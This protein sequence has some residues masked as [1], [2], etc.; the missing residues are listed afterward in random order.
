MPANRGSRS[1]SPNPGTG[2][3]KSRGAKSNKSH[4]SRHSQRGKSTGRYSKLRDNDENEI[5]M[6]DLNNMNLA[7]AEAFKDIGKGGELRPHEIYENT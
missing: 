1:I 5:E 4:K 2:S 3:K 6:M 7:G